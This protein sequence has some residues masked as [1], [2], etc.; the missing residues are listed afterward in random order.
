MS[1]PKPVNW[2]LIE[3]NNSSNTQLDRAT[4]FGTDGWGFESLRGYYE[5]EEE[6]EKVV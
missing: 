6:R 4:D 1:K 3:T 2:E 5:Q